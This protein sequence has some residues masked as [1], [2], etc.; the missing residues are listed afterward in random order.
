[1]LLKVLFCSF[2]FKFKRFFFWFMFMWVVN[3]FV[4]KYLMFYGSL[5][6]SLNDRYI[7][8]ANLAELNTTKKGSL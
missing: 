2:C 8:K 7:Q 4:A 3:L 5:I 6:L 1:M